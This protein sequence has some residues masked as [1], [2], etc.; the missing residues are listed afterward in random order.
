MAR[1]RRPERADQYRD[2]VYRQLQ[3]RLARNVYRLREQK[4]WTQEEAAHQCAMSTRL[5]QQVEAGDVNAT[6]TTVARLCKGL[7]V[8]ATRLLRPMRRA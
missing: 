3:A 1:R 8:D 6:L 4:N 5:L 2:P 7:G